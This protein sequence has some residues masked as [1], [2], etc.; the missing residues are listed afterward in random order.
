[1][2][3]KDGIVGVPAC[4]SPNLFGRR[5]GTP[6]YANLFYL[7]TQAVAIQYNLSLSENS[8]SSVKFLGI[9]IAAIIRNCKQKK[10][11]YSPDQIVGQA[12]WRLTK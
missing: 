4:R 3:G 11:T 9:V 10:E 7:H 2:C 8:C 5:Q 1:M 12:K 6:Y